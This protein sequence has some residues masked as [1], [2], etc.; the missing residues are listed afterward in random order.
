MFE[1]AELG[2]S[3]TDKEYKPLETE[4]RIRL[5]NTQRQ[6]LGRN[7]PVLLMI[8]G[9]DG[10]GRGK[11]INLLSEW[12]DART[13][14]NR[15]FWM[16]SDEERSRPEA[17]RF[18]R[19]LPAKGEM[20]VFFGGWYS[21]AIRT[22][23]CDGM[24]E[25]RF[26]EL[27]HRW[28]RLERMLTASDM[29]IIKL[30]L[31]INRESYEERRKYRL[32]H[33]EIHHFAP[34]DKKSGKNY[35]GLVRAAAQAITITDR[36]NAPWTIIDAHDERFRNAS[37]ARTVIAALEHAL[38]KHAVPSLPAAPDD[39][40]HADPAH[41]RTGGIT[42]LDAIDLTRTCDHDTYSKELAALQDEVSD[43]TYRAYRKGVSSTLVFEGWDAAGKGGAIRRLT[44][45]IDAR[46]TRVIPVSA[47]TDEEQAHHYLWRFWRHVPMAGL[48]TIYDRSWY[49]RVLVERVEHLAPPEAWK[50]AYA[51]INDFEQQLREHNILVVKY[52]L[53]ISEAEQLKRFQ[54]REKVPWKNYKITEDD[55]RN[56]E[57]RPEYLEAADEMFSRTSTLHAPWHIVA[58]EDKKYARLEVIRIYRDTLK[59]ALKR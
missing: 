50:R 8:T 39:I 53:H 2:R 23:C 40:A 49:G 1:S 14:R 44:A 51:E 18:W 26:V 4:L 38:G 17:W 56:R 24:K 54:E 58:A 32:E 29:V 41:G 47:P 21:E 48:V 27:M 46:I 37:V 52:W 3:Y 31:H 22:Y 16:Q 36:V 20:A 59:K 57:K 11:V 42:A 25:K 10:A 28:V 13:I 43:L 30:W 15:T 12:M 45:G 5:F 33:K 6:A 7:M 19:H 34:Y 35:E 55:W 9:V